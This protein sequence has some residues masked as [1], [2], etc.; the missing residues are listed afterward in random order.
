MLCNRKK[1]DPKEYWEDNEDRYYEEKQEAFLSHV[2]DQCLSYLNKTDATE[3]SIQEFA[4]ELEDFTF[5]DIDDWMSSEY[6]DMLG[7]CMDQAYEL[8]RDMEMGL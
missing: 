5:P 4:E 1:Y 8:K 2:K 7:D 3:I 6:A